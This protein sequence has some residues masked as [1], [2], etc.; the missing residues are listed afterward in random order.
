[1]TK[2]TS[3]NDAGFLNIKG[4]L[5]DWIKHGLDERIEYFDGP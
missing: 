5:D 4:V 3:L 1:M 2:F